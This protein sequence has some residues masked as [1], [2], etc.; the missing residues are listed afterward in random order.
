[1]RRRVIVLFVAL[2]ATVVACG[3]DEQRTQT[4]YCEAARANAAA[5]TNPQLRTTADY[6]TI[7]ALYAEMHRKAPLAVEPEWGVMEAMIR[8]AIAVDRTKPTEVAA[9][10]ESAR[11]A[12]TASDRVIAYTQTMCGVLIGNEPLGSTP[13]QAPSGTGA[14]TDNTF[15]FSDV[16]VVD[17]DPNATLPDESIPV[18][19]VVDTVTPAV[20]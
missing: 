1:M 18:S 5:L 6:G 19:S 17:F 7:V 9:V 14:V 2:T 11:V 15:D 10:A 3:D 12:R 8:A 16:T 13:L 4:G 20:S